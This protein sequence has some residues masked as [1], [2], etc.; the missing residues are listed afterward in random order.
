M[1]YFEVFMNKILGPPSYEN[2]KAALSEKN[3]LGGFEVP[4]FTDSHI[5]GE[6][7]DKFGPYQFLN[8]VAI[9]KSNGS[10]T[11][12]IILR[13]DEYLEISIPEMNRT[14]DFHYHGGTLEDEIAALVSLILGVRFRSGGITREFEIDK[15]P[16]GKPILFQMD[17]NPIFL[18]GG[19][20][21]VIPEARCTVN[22]EDLNQF[23]TYPVLHPEDAMTL[24]KIARIYQD[25]LWIVESEPELAWI[26]F[27]SAIETAANHWS[28][29]KATPVERLQTFNPPLE[30]VL[31]DQGGENHV[32]GVAKLIVKYMGA[33]RKFID[34]ILEFLPT[35]PKIRPEKSF[36]HS[37]DNNEIKKTLSKV[38]DYRSRSLHGGKRFPASMCMPPMNLNNIPSEVPTGL[39]TATKGGVW[40]RED[41]P[42]LLHTFEYIVRRALLRWWS[43]LIH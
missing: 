38:Y 39:A 41:T 7:R 5:T 37:W 23:R 9:P 42:I 22:L 33:T 4:L 31:F 25:A 14:D 13:V 11:P 27:V 35:E 29:A 17:K 6:I 12:G 40:T 16:R 21:L 8:P 2:W 18:V 24:V 36:Q 19:D 1:I 43:S 20:G 28:E 3:V 32:R 34:F 30:K 10:I 15:D 26:M